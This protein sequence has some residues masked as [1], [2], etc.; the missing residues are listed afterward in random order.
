M[1]DADIAYTFADISKTR[2]LLG[3][4]PKHPCQG[5]RSFGRGIN[6]TFYS[7]QPQSPNLDFLIPGFLPIIPAGSASILVYRTGNLWLYLFLRQSRKVYSHLI[8][9]VGMGQSETCICR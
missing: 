8:D 1:L 6:R 9:E 7:P 3:T 5:S 4:I 2:K